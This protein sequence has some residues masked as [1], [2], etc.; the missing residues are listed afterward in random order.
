MTVVL[1]TTSMEARA[2]ESQKLLN[3]GFQ[4]FDTVRLFDDGKP[5]VTR[6]GVE[7][8]GSARPSS[9]RAG[10]LF[11]SVPKGEGGKL[12][13]KVERT[14][15]L[16]APLAKGQR[17]G[18]HQGR[19]RGR[20]AGGRRAA[21]GAGAGRAGRHL[22]P[23]LGR[24]PA[25]D[26]VELIGLTQRRRRH[27]DAL[28]DTLCYLNGEYLPLRRGQGLG[29]RPR[30]PLRRRHLRGRAGLR[31]AAVPLRRAHGAAR[32]AAW[33][34]CASTTRTTA[35][36]WLERCREADRRAAERGG[37]TD[38]L[39]YIQVT[40]GVALR[41]HVMPAGIEPT[42]FMMA[43]ADEAGHAGEQRHQGV[44]CVS[45]RDFRW[46]RGDIKSI[47]L[48]G[49]VLARQIVGRPR[50]GRDDHVPRRLPDRG[51]GVAT[52]GSCTRARCSAPPKSEHVLEGIRYEL[53]G[54]LC[55]EC[56]IAYNLRP[57][58]E[59]DVRRR[60]RDA[61]QLGHQGGPAG[62]DAR[63][64]GRSATA[65][66]AASPGRS[67]RGCTRP[68]SAPSDAVDLK[69]RAIC[70]APTPHI[71]AMDT[72]HARHPARAVADRIPVALSRSR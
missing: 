31:Q 7:G 33:P 68:T 24:D 22:R 14:D 10:A 72:T 26:Q 34:S 2:N 42:V 54:E 47:S 38:Q 51:G 29:A 46:E 5:I 1:N 43:S 12:Q 70:T 21:G 36:Q 18:T 57:I 41:D 27:A 23:R 25:L 67:T 37:A 13:T 48:L 9:A 16:V 49:N 66:C 65:R 53:I 71:G 19:D 44:A 45:A 11:V 6:A 32:T 20:H 58:A 39:V 4:A 28:P 62:D 8:H 61:A 35:T 63:R 64:R 17:V 69:R 30:L 40:R 15:P 52:S 50:R 56:G 59:A 60:R 3:W 55:E